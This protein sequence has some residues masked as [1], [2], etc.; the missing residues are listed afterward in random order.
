[1]KKIV[2]CIQNNG[3]FFVD[4]DGMVVKA[5]ETFEF[6]WATHDCVANKKLLRVKEGNNTVLIVP[7]ERLNYLR[8][9][10]VPEEEE[11]HETH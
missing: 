8:V 7:L 2:V 9:V 5:E 4:Q 10:D 6:D 11:P 1:M 3:R